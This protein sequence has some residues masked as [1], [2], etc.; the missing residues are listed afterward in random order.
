MFANIAKA[1][2]LDVNKSILN[3]LDPSSGNTTLSTLLID[4]NGLRRREGM[5]IY[6]F[7]ESAGK[8]GLRGLSGKVCALTTNRKRAIDV[9]RLCRTGL[10]LLEIASSNRKTPSMQITWRCVAFLVEVMMAI[11]SP[12]ELLRAF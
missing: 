10:R 8:Y 4:F 3:E 6:T 7:Q 12:S 2:Q 9:P 5:K 1:A 11:K